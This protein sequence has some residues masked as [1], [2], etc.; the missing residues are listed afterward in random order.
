M[1]AHRAV[2]EFLAFTQPFSG[3]CTF[4][5]GLS[6]TKLLA[7][8][9]GNSVTCDSDIPVVPWDSVADSMPQT[10]IYTQMTQGSR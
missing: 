2:Q 6:V 1:F 5:M 4:H 8:I 10:T 9:W 3:R 7:V